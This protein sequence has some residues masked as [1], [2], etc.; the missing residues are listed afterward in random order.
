MSLPIDN[1]ATQI[2]VQKNYATPT[3]REI[4]PEQAKSL[5]NWHASRGN[6]DAREL[7][8]LLFPEPTHAHQSRSDEECPPG[9]AH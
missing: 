1:P 8:E 5:L 2:D 4:T 7:L 3:L 9:R 6:R